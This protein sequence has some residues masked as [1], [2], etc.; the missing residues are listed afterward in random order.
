[1]RRTTDHNGAEEPSSTAGSIIQNLENMQAFIKALTGLNLP[2]D[3]LFS[4]ADLEYDGPEDRHKVVSCLLS[5]KALQE[6]RDGS[7]QARPTVQQKPSQQQV[8]QAQSEASLDSMENSQPSSCDTSVV[9]RTNSATSGGN[10][11]TSGRMS[12]RLSAQNVT[13]LMKK[14]TKMLEEKS[15]L[16]ASRA[17]HQQH[18]AGVGPV[19]EEAEFSGALQKTLTGLMSSYETQLLHKS[20]EIRDREMKLA[21]ANEKLERLQADL[22]AVQQQFQAA[23]AAAADA[24]AADAKGRIA[25]LEAQVASLKAALAAKEAELAALRAR[26]DSSGEAR[27]SQLAQA[28]AEVA[29]LQE[30]C[31]QLQV[32]EGKYRATHEENRRLYNLVQVRKAARTV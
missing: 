16:D 3:N 1:M 23:Q 2:G 9:E 6:S 22:A 24:A 10:G 29:R 27:D 31:C 5:L 20:T 12:A 28:Q 17:S 8:T 15:W 11:P 21:M 32:V 18:G 25:Q 13:S 30:Q 4:I 7:S 26:L 14:C 19:C